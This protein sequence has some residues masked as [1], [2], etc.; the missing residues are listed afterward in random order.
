MI[1]LFKEPLGPQGRLF[2]AAVQLKRMSY[3]MTKMN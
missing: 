3:H 2:G 1:A